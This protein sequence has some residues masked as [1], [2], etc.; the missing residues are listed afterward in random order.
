MVQCMLPTDHGGGKPEPNAWSGFAAMLS[1]W[2]GVN[3]VTAKWLVRFPAL[4]QLTKYPLI[5]VAG[6]EISCTS[7]N[8]NDTLR[9]AMRS[10]SHMPAPATPAGMT[11]SVS[12]RIVMP[13]GATA[14]MS[15]L[16]E[17][18]GLPGGDAVIVVFPAA[19]GADQR[20][21]GAF[22]AETGN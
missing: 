17:L 11:S 12:L 5:P 18:A 10:S 14:E 19:E 21:D 9:G 1:T 3:L 4:A 13:E 16:D 20:K 8:P 7:M 2:M 15:I 6:P 22:L